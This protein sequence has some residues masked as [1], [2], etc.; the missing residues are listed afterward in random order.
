MVDVDDIVAWF[1]F[2][3]RL[4]GPGTFTFELLSLPVAF[5]ENIMICEKQDPDFIQFNSIAQ[6]TQNNIKRCFRI[7]CFEVAVRFKIAEEIK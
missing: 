7:V 5:P 2:K 3:K 1:K 4:N 6:R